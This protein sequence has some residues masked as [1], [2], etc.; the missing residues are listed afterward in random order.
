M[1]ALD[2]RQAA[3]SRP[4]YA[5]PY[6]E[7]RS[8]RER[9]YGEERPYREEP[10]YGEDRTYPEERAYGGTWAYPEERIDGEDRAYTDRP[11]T[12]HPYQERQPLLPDRTYEDEPL[13]ARAYRDPYQERVYPEPARPR[14][15]PIH[16]EPVHPET[17]YRTAS[18]QERA[19]RDGPYAEE[20]YEERP[21]QERSQEHGRERG[22]VPAQRAY[23]DPYG[24]R[25]PT[26]D[27]ADFTPTDVLPA[28]RALALPSAGERLSP[29]QQ[30][31]LLQLRHAAEAVLLAFKDSPAA[32][33]GP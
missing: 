14:T 19:Y 26:P 4:R 13:P 6:R 24:R 27:L 20:P 33:H 17:T 15:G 22:A 30:L 28:L 21:H 1:T 2:D 10:P 29:R 31:A 3:A 18:Y 9:P 25:R 8:Y 5:P 23:R 11:Y 12:D 7:E 16:P 32:R